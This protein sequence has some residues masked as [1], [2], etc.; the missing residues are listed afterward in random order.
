MDFLTLPGYVHNI[1][2]KILPLEEQRQL[3][4]H[5]VFLMVY[6][7]NFSVNVLRHIKLDEKMGVELLIK[8]VK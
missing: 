7:Y 8:M 5:L 3:E 4:D 6:E 1:S 2:K